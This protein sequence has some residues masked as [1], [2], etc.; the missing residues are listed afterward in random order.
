MN[1]LNSSENKNAVTAFFGDIVACVKEHYPVIILCVLGFL[2]V[3]GINIF[4]M[5][6]T[7]TISSF[8]LE[9]FEVGQISDRTVFA[10]RTIPADEMNP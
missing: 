7:Q 5:S 2:A 4:D 3:T 1:K 10:P 8:R 6:M 9:D